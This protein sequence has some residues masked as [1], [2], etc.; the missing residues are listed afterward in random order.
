MRLQIRNAVGAILLFLLACNAKAQIKEG[1]YAIHFTDKKQTTFDLTSPQTFLSARSVE[2]KDRFGIP[3]DSTDLPVNQVY[4][5]SIANYF[6]VTYRFSSKWFNVGIFEIES[7]ATLN[8]ILDLGFV[9][10]AAA[11][12][13]LK[14]NDKDVQQESVVAVQ[15]TANAHGESY[16][17]LEMIGLTQLHNWGYTGDGMRIAVLDAGF[18]NVNNIA[19]FNHLFPS[20]IVHAWDVIT[21]TTNIYHSGLDS[22]GRQV[23]SILAARD[24]GEY[25]GS[26]PDAEYVLIRTEDVSSESLLEEWSWI[27]GMEI[28]DS[29]GV[30]VIN[31]SLGYN[32]F[33]GGLNNHAY[34]DLD[35]N[36]TVAAL[37]ALVAAR[38]G[39]ALV[40]SMGN[41][42]QGRIL[43]PADADSILAV[44]AADASGNYATFSS[45]GP[46]ADGRVKPDVSAWGKSTRYIGSTGNV[47]SSNGTSY[48]API[49]AGAVACLWQ[50][51]P[52]LDA[53]TLLQA[54]R[55]TGHQYSTPD[56][57]LGYGIPNFIQAGM[58]LNVEP[59]GEKKADYAPSFEVV[60]SKD[61]RWMLRN[62]LNELQ[63]IQIHA[64]NG[65]HITN[66]ALPAAG[67]LEL[68]AGRLGYGVYLIK[69][70]NQP[71]V[72]KVSHLRD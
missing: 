39:L 27:S 15:K 72:L 28:A 21:Q 26:A 67:F 61:G 36:T 1:T 8:D 19:P 40:V 42:G 14:T 63:H 60:F 35:G 31:T 59:V 47:V 56:S 57:L 30:D 50:Q 5:D 22:H 6:P 20:Q 16:N 9:K 64:V 53:Q 23:L 13:V 32:T 70:S 44:G 48:A 66:L 69:S 12:P 33:D 71:T 41:E 38:K 55:E 65:Q 68:D 25:I 43:T 7:T 29:L 10:G 54:V 17:Q 45:V 51:F 62:R 2:R 3:I 11:Y 18:K 24:S 34:N 4:I 49:I 52:D 37:G 58:N 46:A